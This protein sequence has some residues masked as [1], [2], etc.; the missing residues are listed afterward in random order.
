MSAAIDLSGQ[1]FGQLVAIRRVGTNKNNQAIWLCY[2]DCGFSTETLCA[3]LRSGM[4]RS[5]GCLHEEQRLRFPTQV[6]KH[7]EG[8]DSPEYR[9]WHLMLLRCRNPKAPN[10]SYYGGR[11]ITVCERWLD[12]PAFLADMGRK[13]TPSHSIERVDNQG[14]YEPS[15]C[16]W[17]TK[18]QQSRN[19]RRADA[20]ARAVC[21]LSQV[22]S[23]RLWTRFQ[24]S[25]ND[26]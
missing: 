3:Q 15:N 21:T 8:Y 1:R 22:M 25:L 11:G 14:N 13:P 5:C 6:Y 18:S 12:Y 4:T 26:E 17:A 24:L 9:C 7:G 16:V 10:Y 19:R 20:M 2:C 23:P